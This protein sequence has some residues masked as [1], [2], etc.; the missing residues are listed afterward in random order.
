MDIFLFK[1]AKFTFYRPLR[2]AGLLV[3]IFEPDGVLFDEDRELTKNAF[4]EIGPKFIYSFD[5]FEYSF[6]WEEAG[7]QK[8]CFS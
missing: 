5:L 6:L 7:V 8:I 4:W 1:I 2:C 3:E